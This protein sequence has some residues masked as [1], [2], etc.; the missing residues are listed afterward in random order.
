MWTSSVSLHPPKV[1]V[2]A[3][4]SSKELIGPFF[5]RQTILS[6]VYL[7]ILRGFVTVHNA[8]EDSEDTS[9]FM[10]DDALPYLWIYALDWHSIIWH[11]FLSSIPVHVKVIFQG[12]A[13]YMYILWYIIFITKW[14]MKTHFLPSIWQYFDIC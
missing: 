1:M 7:D 12:N 3:G 11:R 13:I 9:W 10:Q 5:W 14:I 8:L 6:E 4:I 2:W